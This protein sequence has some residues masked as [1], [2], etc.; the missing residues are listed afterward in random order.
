MSAEYRP[1]IEKAVLDEAAFIRATFTGLVP[2]AEEPWKKVTLRTVEIRGV[3]HVQFSYF[4]E[5]RCIAKNYRGP[6][7]YAALTQL[8]DWPVRNVSLDTTAESIQVTV[9]VNGKVAI[10]RQP[11]KAVEAVR[12]HDRKKSLLLPDGEPNAYLQA[13]GF[14]TKDGQIRADKQRKF[15]QTNEFL[16]FLDQTGELEKLDE[17]PIHVV[18]FGCGNAYL[19]FAVYHFLNSVKQIPTRVTGIDTREDLLAN[20][21]QTAADLG[22]ADFSFLAQRIEEYVPD[23]PPTIAIALH[24]CDTATDDALAMAIRH[25]S[26]IILSVPCCHHHLQAQLSAAA[27]PAEMAAAMQHGILLERM[28]DILTDAFRAQ[29]LRMHGYETDVIQFVSAEHTAKNVLIR[30]VLRSGSPS[31]RVAEEYA[32]MKAFWGVTPY[33]EKLISAAAVV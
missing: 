26:K 1:L 31:P 8:L 6:E 21:R 16:K 24:A 5:R 30:A 12:A 15:K 33:L 9:A 3:P 28:G 4:D 27:P 18:D 7:L 32:A 2:T 10:R 11:A 20:H 17:R 14:M 19:T 29:I 13:I 23:S 25:G 22:W